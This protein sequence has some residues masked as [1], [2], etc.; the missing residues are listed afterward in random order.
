MR[1]LRKKQAS[2]MSL[3]F[4]FLTVTNGKGANPGGATPAGAQGNIQSGKA[5][6][7]TFTQFLNPELKSTTGINPDIN[8]Q[9]ADA[10]LAGEIVNA[11]EGITTTTLLSQTE[12]TE[13]PPGQNEIPGFTNGVTP[14]FN[15]AQLDALVEQLGQGLNLGEFQKDSG[16]GLSTAPAIETGPIVA[17]LDPK[18]GA[19]LQPSTSPAIETGPIVAGLD[20]KLV[21]SPQ[22]STT[23]GVQVGPI[24][25][26]FDP[27]TVT[28]PQP[29]T[30]PGAQTGPIIAGLDPKAVT[31]PQPSTVPSVQTGPIIAGLDSKTVTAPQPST[32]PGVPTGPIVAGLDPKTVAAPQL[33]TAPAIQTGPIVAGQVP[34]ARG[35]SGT[36][37]NNL[38]VEALTEGAA[39]LRGFSKPTA[40][41]SGQSGPKTSANKVS[42]TLTASTSTANA[43]AGNPVI[44]GAS[45]VLAQSASVQAEALPGFEKHDLTTKA[46]EPFLANIA[47]T[48][49]D[50]RSN[51]LSTEQGQAVRSSTGLDHGAV[52][53]ANITQ[54]STPRLDQAGLNSFAASMVQRVQGGGT[55]FEIRLDPAELGRVQVRLEVSPDNR[56]E[57]VLSSQRP[58]VL[59]DLQRGADALRRALSD[60]GFEVGSDGLSFSLEQGAEGF[61]AYQDHASDAYEA[62]EFRQDGALETEASVLAQSERGYGLTRVYDG[63]IDVTL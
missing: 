46:A 58:E 1:A 14:Y 56:V 15:A 32:V 30:T 2:G 42:T 34:T 22:P 9:S 54:Q 29:S 23:P 16:P 7:I 19:N 27:K 25:A 37:E 18:L 51:F 10:G 57:A 31:S 62:A 21:A 11:F 6:G 12:Q 28:V 41:G 5:Q 3:D 36:V 63:R 40:A 53:S 39:R 52:K 8:I 24:V 55:R 61:E 26:G 60:M 38:L 43:A 44:N 20:P 33:S 4:N 59:A 49:V 47:D 50:G 17:G 48:S 35:T 13:T 45:L